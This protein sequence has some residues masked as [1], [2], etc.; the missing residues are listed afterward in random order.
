[1]RRLRS[2]LAGRI[3][4]VRQPRT[5]ARLARVLWAIL[6]VVVWNVVLDH[7]IVRAGRDY[8]AAVGRASVSH[9]TRPNMDAYMRPAVTR[10]V[11]IATVAGALVLAT[12]LL[13]VGAAARMSSNR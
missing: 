4:A 1:M 10:G 11:W 3:A 9:A 8:I 5:A 7:V 12:G 13:S 2:N 6:A